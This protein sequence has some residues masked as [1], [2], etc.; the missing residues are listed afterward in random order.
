MNNKKGFTMIKNKEG[1]TIIEILISVAILS[2]VIV[3]ILYGFSQR[4]QT[5]RNTNLKNT[6]ITLAEAKLE[7]YLKFPSS[8]MAAALPA[9]AVDYIVYHATSQPVI[10][11]S[12]PHINRQYRRTVNVTMDGNLAIINI[13]VDYG[14]IEKNNHYPFSVTLT[15]QRGL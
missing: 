3:S 9:S 14:Y 8:Q 10:S 6:A 13:T 1:F 7:E 11:T 4:M 2:F 12:N 15:S 5:D